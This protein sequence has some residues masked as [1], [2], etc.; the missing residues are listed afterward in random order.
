MIKAGSKVKYVASDSAYDKASGFYPPKDTIGTVKRIDD[1]G[2]WVQ[3]NEGTKKG[4]WFCFMQDLE[5]VKTPVNISLIIFT[6]VVVAFWSWIIASVINTNIA[7]M[8]D[9]PAT[10]AAW[11]FFEIVARWIK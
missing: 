7:N 3:W 9:N 6:V 1:V 8:P 11:N 5:E 2:A 4:T 10:P